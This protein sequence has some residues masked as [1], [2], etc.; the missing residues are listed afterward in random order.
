MICSD[1][2]GP[3]SVQV[4]RAINESGKFI[5]QKSLHFIHNQK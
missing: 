1:N 3:G 5:F 4:N 2:V